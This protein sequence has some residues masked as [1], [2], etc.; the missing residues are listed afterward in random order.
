MADAVL[1]LL[2]DPVKAAQFRKAGI[3]SAQRY[4]WPNVRD[5]LLCVYEQA[6][7]K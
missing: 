7:T 5:R 3:E 6:L 2:S 1:A 4:T